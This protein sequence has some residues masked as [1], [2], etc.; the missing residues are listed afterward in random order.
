MITLQHFS[1]S[2][3]LSGK[4][5]TGLIFDDRIVQCMI[6]FILLILGWETAYAKTISLLFFFSLLETVCVSI[7]TYIHTHIHTHRHTHTQKYKCS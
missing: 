7:Y 3:C 5:F 2:V 4:V 6:R 1:D